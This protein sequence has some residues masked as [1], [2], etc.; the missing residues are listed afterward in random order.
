M[1]TYFS[2]IK[3]TQLLFLSISIA[4]L[5]ILPG[6]L[7]LYPGSV[8]TAW[9]YFIAHTSLFLVMVIRPLADVAS[10]VRFIR[11][12]VSLRKGVGVFSA[13]F[14][15][16]FIIAKLIIDPAG[17]FA[18]FAQASYWSFTNLALFAHLADISAILL[19][20][21]SNNFSKRMLGANWKRLQRLSYVYF[22]GSGI[23][24]V[25]ALGDYLVLAY[26]IIVTVL[27]LIAFGVNKTRRT[28]QA[29]K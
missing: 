13:S 22:Y 27:T 16:S 26:L 7:V 28:L 5:A 29:Q 21:T 14:I 8:D 11:P 6:V 3:L 18:G 9:L 25:Y 20:V 12:L 24:V 17:Y 19:L 23:Y 15:V 1:K 10:G 2:L 4:I